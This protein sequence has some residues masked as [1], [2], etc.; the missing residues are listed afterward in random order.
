M[1]QLALLALF[2][3]TVPTMSSVS[4]KYLIKSARASAR[5]FL[6]EGCLPAV[7]IL[8]GC[9]IG[10]LCARLPIARLLLCFVRVASEPRQITSPTRS[11][12]YAFLRKYRAL[13]AKNSQISHF[14]HANFCTALFALS[15]LSS[16]IVQI[17][18]KV[19]SIFSSSI[20]SGLNQDNV[21][22]KLKERIKR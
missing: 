7:M 5:A 17:V 20:L 15:A 8:I 10:V 18:Q 14:S 6:F 21:V 9:L 1:T 16:P 3:Q 13:A 2:C 12:S 11:E 4:C 19:Q 22:V